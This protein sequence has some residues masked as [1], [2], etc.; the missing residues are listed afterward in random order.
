MSKAKKISYLEVDWLLRK[1]FN[2]LA[3]H[4]KFQSSGEKKFLFL[5]FRVLKHGARSVFFLSN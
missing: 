1:T 5:D 3:T 2:W 4:Y